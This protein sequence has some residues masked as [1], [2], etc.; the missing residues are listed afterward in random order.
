MNPALLNVLVNFGSV[1]LAQ[2]IPFGSRPEYVL[3]ARVWFV[4]SHIAC[5]VVYYYCYDKADRRNDLRPLKYMNYKSKSDKPHVTTVRDY[6]LV[7]TTTGMTNV[8]LALLF[9]G[10]L[11]V[12]ARYTSPLVA[13]SLVLSWHSINAP[14]VK[15]WFWGRPATGD[16]ARPF[17]AS[18]RI[19][20]PDDAAQGTAK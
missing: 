13:E 20:K 18:Q 7:E 6:D 4:F 10:F 12:Y 9:V 15:V 2:S 19:A 11:H 14:V 17:H 3:W 5:I 8:F 16:L 1:L